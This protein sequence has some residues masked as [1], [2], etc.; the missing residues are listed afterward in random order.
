MGVDGRPFGREGMVDIRQHPGRFRILDDLADLVLE[1]VGGG[2]IGLLIGDQ[3]L[4]NRPETQAAG[5]PGVFV[6]GVPAGRVDVQ[7][8]G[9]GNAERVTVGRGLHNSRIWS[10]SLRIYF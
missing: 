10:C 9:V 1:E 7:G 8:G 4:K 3:V 6:Q 2:V 5:F